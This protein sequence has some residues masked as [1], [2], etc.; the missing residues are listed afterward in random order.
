MD[1]KLDPKGFFWLDFMVSTVVALVM[2]AAL[3]ELIVPSSPAKRKRDPRS[4]ASRS[5]TT[6]V[7]AIRRDLRRLVTVSDELSC[8]E[9]IRSGGRWGDRLH[10]VRISADATEIAFYVPAGDD[11]SGKRARPKADAVNYRLL[12]MNDPTGSIEARRRFFLAR[13]FGTT[14]SHP[15][16]AGTLVRSSGESVTVFLKDIRFRLVDP[17]S[18]DTRDLST[19]KG[20]CLEVSLVAT[21]SQGGESFSQ[22]EV[23]PLA[24]P[25]DRTEGSPAN[26]P[27]SVEYHPL[28][29]LRTQP[30]QPDLTSMEEA[31]VARIRS[32]AREY[33]RDPSRDPDGL[34]NAIETSLDAL[35]R[36]PEGTGKVFVMG[37]N[38]PLCPGP[39]LVL[40][41]I[42]GQAP[43]ILVSGSLVTIPTVQ[44]SP[45]T[46]SPEAIRP[47]GQ[48]IPKTGHLAWGRHARAWRLNPETG[49]LVEV[50]S[51]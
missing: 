39:V 29:A 12:P 37:G 30:S 1:Q 50:P 22:L 26:P 5:A 34:K 21:D 15:E 49:K 35:S 25:R 36:S 48:S 6:A 27:A 3:H 43:Q 45:W 11:I 33:E 51:L 41:Q 19:G 16:E 20:S 10:P 23:L 9:E 47:T 46:R 18:A 28:Q 24:P 31:I 44:E 40:P 17:S 7:E 13:F 32:A 8:G 42:P 2:L 4:E 14:L 38:G